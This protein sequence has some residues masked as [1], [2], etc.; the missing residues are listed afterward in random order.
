MKQNLGKR[1]LVRMIQTIISC[2]ILSLCSPAVAGSPDRNEAEELLQKKPLIKIW[3][4]SL[5][6][7]ENF[8]SIA[9][10]D[11]HFPVALCDLSLE[12]GDEGVTKIRYKCPAFYKGAPM[13]F[14]LITSRK[15]P[16]W[17]ITRIERNG[18]LLD[19]DAMQLFANDPLLEGMGSFQ[20]LLLDMQDLEV[21]VKGPNGLKIYG[22]LATMIEHLKDTSYICFMDVQALPETQIAC[23]YFNEKLQ[24]YNDDDKFLFHFTQITEKEIVLTGVYGKLQDK[25]LSADGLTGFAEILFKP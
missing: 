21:S 4:P 16:Y 17:T 19:P 11:H 15:T 9:G 6:K 5:S 2:S 3:L 14:L 1:A 8:A 10:L 20:R 23:T 22:K 18:Q 13:S 25:Q 12:N 24:R 7:I